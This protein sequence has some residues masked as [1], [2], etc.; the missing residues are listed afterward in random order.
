MIN[1]NPRFYNDSLE[2]SSYYQLDVYEYTA[3]LFGQNSISSVLDLG[4]GMATKLR[5]YIRP[6]CTDIT[7]I[8]SEHAISQCRVL[9]DFGSWHTADLE[10]NSYVLPRSYDLIICADVIEHLKN[11]DSLLRIIKSGSHPGTVVVLSTPERDLRRGFGDMGP[12]QNTAHVREWNEDEFRAYL[13]DRGFTIEHYDIVHLC[14]DLK[15]CQL[16][17]GHFPNEP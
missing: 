1:E 15:T 3:S 13:A 5:D 12:P 11:P 8:D 2:D 6:H 7:G 14:K 4:C 16:A 17:M 9:Y 10:D